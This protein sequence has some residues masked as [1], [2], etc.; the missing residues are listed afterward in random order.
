MYPKG[1]TRVT[2]PKGAMGMTPAA[3]SSS[4]GDSAAGAA[5]THTTL[6]ANQT[7]VGA[8]VVLM[9]CMQFLRQFTQ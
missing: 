7:G 9:P 8:G 1:G 6:A 3:L 4:K 2:K 5:D